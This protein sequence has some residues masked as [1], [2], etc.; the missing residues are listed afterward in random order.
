MKSIN[1]VGLESWTDIELCV[2]S[3][4]CDSVTPLRLLEHISV[5]PSPHSQAGIEYKTANGAATAN[6]GE[7]RLDAVT[8]NA[9]I[10]PSV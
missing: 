3:G 2:N 10:R 4:A 6:V 7:Q 8:T 9:Q 1:A 5:V